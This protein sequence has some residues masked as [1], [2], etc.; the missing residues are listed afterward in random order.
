[1][2]R[3]VWLPTVLGLL[4]GLLLMVYPIAN[5]LQTNQLSPLG[6]EA[7]FGQLG[8]GLVCVVASL[9]AGFGRIRRDLGAGSLMT[10][11]VLIAW[12]YAWALPTLVQVT[13]ILLFLPTLVGGVLALAAGVMMATFQVDRPQRAERA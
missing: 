3:R 6:P 5:W 9:A 7:L 8:T 4:A 2:S 11:G 12:G 10:V 13:S 1:M